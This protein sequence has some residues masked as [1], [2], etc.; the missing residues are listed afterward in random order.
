MRA[1]DGR[2]P[3]VD[4]RHVRRHAGL[5]DKRR[6]PGPARKTHRRPD[7][8]GDR[9][10]RRIHLLR[11]DGHVVH[12]A[13]G[14]VNPWVG[15][16]PALAY[17]LSTYFLLIIGAGHVTKMWALVYA[18]ADDGRRMGRPA[19]Q[20]LVRRGRHGPRRIARNRRQP[21]AD[22][23]LFPR[24]DGRI[25]G[26]RG[27]R[28]P[29][30]KDGCGTSPCARR[31]SPRRACWPRDRTSRPSGTRP[32]T[33]RRPSA[34]A[35]SWPP[36]AKAP[37]TDWR[38]T[39]PR[40]GATARAET[41][42]L[43]VPDFMGR[44]SGT[45]LPADGETAA[46]LDGYGLRGA[47]QQLPAYWGTQPYT[48]GPTYLGAAAVF[49]AALG[50]ALAGGRNKW[51]IV[52]VCAVMILLAWGRNLMGFTELAFR[53]PARIR[54]VPHRLDDAGRRPVGR[55]GARGIGPRTAL[56]RRR[57]AP[58]PAARTGLVGGRHGRRLPA[59][60]R[61]RR[62]A[63]RLRARRKRGD[64]DRTVPP[65]LRGERHAG[66]HLPRHGRRMG[67]RHRRGDGCRPRRDDALRRLAVASDDP[68]RG[69]LRRALRPAADREIR[70]HGPAGG[71]SY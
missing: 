39:T 63:V 47:A 62:L 61:G 10:P 67:R 45:T 32:S 1:V 68:A 34:A 71:A 15:T 52:A 48:G 54:Q 2:R 56:E 60:G 41:L 50:I 11:H 58:A 53:I 66:I 5:P 65:H 9:H 33:R 46:L 57:S 35:R 59:A 40:R 28:R 4:R 43:L 70:A 7:R 23:L 16:V 25:L 30:A 14:G 3:A 38:S 51:W 42:N 6:L 22:H 37:A 24:G 20:R 31:R 21:S 49:L 69:G 29:S 55:A 13:H 12:A 64:D 26:E 8:Q 36:G 19:R 17:G 18:P 27:R 44:D